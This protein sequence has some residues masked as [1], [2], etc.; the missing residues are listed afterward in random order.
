M[1][2][3]SVDQIIDQILSH[4]NFLKLK[5]VIENIPQIHDNEDVYTHSLNTHKVAKEFLVNPPITDSKALNFFKEFMSQSLEGYKRNEIL[6]IVALLHDSGKITEFTENGKRHSIN[7]HR[8]NMLPENTYCPGHEYLGSKLIV[9]S[10]LKGVFSEKIIA[11]IQ[12]LVRLHD[13]FN[14]YFPKDWSDEEILYDIKFR[15][16]GYFIETLFNSYC[17][18]YFAPPFATTRNSILKLLNNPS[19]YSERDYYISE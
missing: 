11:Y 15:A 8:P 17:D 16:E 14:H 12:D 13:T 4:P 5:N 2:I 1:T 10:I 3:F 7:S 6:L 9:P 19:L 18:T